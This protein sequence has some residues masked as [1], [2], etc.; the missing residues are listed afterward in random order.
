MRVLLTGTGAADGIPGLFSGSRVS[1]HARLAGGK[2]V[3]SRSSAVVDGVLRIDLGPDTLSQVHRFGLKSREWKNILVTHSD[4][5]HFAPSELQY[6]FPPFTDEGATLPA[7]YG[8]RAVL[9]RL[10][11]AFD[12]AERL[13]KHLLKSYET[14]RVGDYEVTPI[15]AYHKLDEDSL[16]LIIKEDKTFL[17]ASDTGVYRDETWEFL[18]GRRFDAAVIECTDGFNAAEYLGHLS[19]Q[20][21][22]DVVARL[23]EM[24]CL[25]EESIVCTTHHGHCGM[26]THSELE[27][28][29]TPHG[30]QVGYDGKVLDF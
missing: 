13:T 25:D 5:D 29:L 10:S 30:V 27:E 22:L 3:R 4:D 18:Q 8:N 17:Y 15:R 24:G 9:D 11:D 16:N 19:A 23:R 26:A 6:L 12:K 1:E 14:V 2:D 28:F 7:V 21:L 20:E